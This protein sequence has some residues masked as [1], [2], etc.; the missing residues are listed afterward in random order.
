MS[1][2]EDVAVSVRFPVGYLADP[3]LDLNPETFVKINSANAK[4]GNESD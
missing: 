3:N 4:S 2:T 1:E